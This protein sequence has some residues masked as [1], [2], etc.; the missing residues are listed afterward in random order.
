MMIRVQIQLR[1]TLCLLNSLLN[2]RI[3]TTEQHF[4]VVKLLRRNKC[5]WQLLSVKKD[6]KYS[7]EASMFCWV[8]RRGVKK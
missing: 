6:E 4:N 2:L 5:Q 1:Y 3:D 7:K 8:L